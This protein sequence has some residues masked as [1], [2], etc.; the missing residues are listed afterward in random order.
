MGITITS[1][2]I[3]HPVTNITTTTTVQ[4][5][6]ATSNTTSSEGFE[7]GVNRWGQ[8]GA[9][10]EFYN[11]DERDI[12]YVDFQLVPFNNVG[13]VVGGIG[14]MCTVRATNPTDVQ[15]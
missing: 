12:K 13:D 3:G 14:S 15:A 6:F 8:A 5:G 1:F 7:P 10:I 2:G 4:D 11:E 9:K